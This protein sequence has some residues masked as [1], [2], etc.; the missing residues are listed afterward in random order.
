MNG[1]RSKPSYTNVT[2]H[3]FFYRSGT[4]AGALFFGESK[5]GLLPQ[6]FH[7]FV[8]HPFLPVPVRAP[9]S[10]GI[11]D[12]AYVPTLPESPPS[13]FSCP[14]VTYVRVPWNHLIT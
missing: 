8:L 6:V 3:V 1:Y 14:W 5:L 13:S 10:C 9:E 2:L 11:T 4:I 12:L 7:P